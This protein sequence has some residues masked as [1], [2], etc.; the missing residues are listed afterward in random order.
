M[1]TNKILLI[2]ALAVSFPAMAELTEGDT[3]LFSQMSDAHMI[4]NNAVYQAHKQEQR[5][6]RAAQTPK[7]NHAT[8]QNSGSKGSKKVKSRS[9]NNRKADPLDAL[10]DALG[11]SAAKYGLPE[12]YFR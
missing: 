3:A 2:A 6:A 12:E 5:A 9:Q 11:K 10:G 8:K 7:R 4:D 1:R